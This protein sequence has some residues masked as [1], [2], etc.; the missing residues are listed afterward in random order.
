MNDNVIVKEYEFDNALTQKL[1]SLIKNFLRDCHNNYY[2]TFGYICEHDF[3][4]TNISIYQMINLTISDKIMAS[5]ELNKK[6]N[7]AHGNGFIFNQIN[8]LTTI[9]HSSNL[10]IINIH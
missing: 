7:V 6:L 10:S 8:K 3:Q 2:H 4:L 5:Y 1:D 9:K